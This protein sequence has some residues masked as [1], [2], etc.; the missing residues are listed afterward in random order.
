M[1]KVCKKSWIAAIFLGVMLFA[2]GFAFQASTVD[3]QAATTGFRTVKGKTY[4]YK[5]GKKV[6]GW[7]TLNGKKY[8]LNTRTG[9]L[10]K[11]WQRS[12]RGP[13]RY[14][15]KKNGVMYTGMKKIG[16]K[17]YYFD[18]K[19]GYTKRGFVRS[20]NGAVVRYFQPSNYT[21]A[22]G[23]LKNAKGQK[24]Y[25]ASDGKMYMGL[26]KIGKYYYYFNPSTGIA[27]SGYVNTGNETRYFNAKYKRMVS[28]WTKSAKGELR[29]FGS[30]RCYGQGTY[31]GWQCYILF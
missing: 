29:Y 16:G 15:N 28:G 3:A 21:M 13:K 10:L 12:S 9:V 30:Q 22:K 5:N 20:A 25:F 11:G 14:F 6:K 17:Y 23:W 2:A 18:I 31:K 27:A 7:L 1:G 19:T 24:W 26:K 4:Y 8:F